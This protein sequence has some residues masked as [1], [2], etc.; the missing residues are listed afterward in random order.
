[1]NHPVNSVNRTSANPTPAIHEGMILGF[2]PGLSITGYG[3]LRV[4]NQ[5]PELIEAGILKM[6]RDRTLAQRL[7][8]LHDGVKEIL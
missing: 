3:I 7:R 2:D 8:E 1:M 6:R 4:R 5:Q